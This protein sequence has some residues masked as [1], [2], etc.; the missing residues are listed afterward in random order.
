MIKMGLNTFFS[1]LY[2][3]TY[4]FKNSG[5]QLLGIAKARTYDLLM[6]LHVLIVH[7][8]YKLFDCTTFVC[9]FLLCMLMS[10]ACFRLRHLLTLTMYAVHLTKQ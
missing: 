10:C 5:F 6:R 7:T 3:I 9:K 2:K 1:N 8:D 4:L